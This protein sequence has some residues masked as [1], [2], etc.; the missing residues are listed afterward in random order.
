MR[1][2]RR[3]AG[4]RQCLSRFGDLNNPAIRVCAKSNA[5]PNLDAMFMK[6]FTTVAFQPVE[7]ERVDFAGIRSGE[8]HQPHAWNNAYDLA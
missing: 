7:S 4:V 2:T 3:K 1:R 6:R 5:G 8:I